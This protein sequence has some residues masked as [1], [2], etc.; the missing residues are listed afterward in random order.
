MA[1][2]EGA[3]A[4]ASARTAWCRR[5]TPRSFR[6]SARARGSTSRRWRAKAAA[7]TLAIPF[8]KQLTG[9]GRQRSRRR[10]RVM[11]T[12]APPARTSSTPRPCFASSRRARASHELDA[13][14][15]GDAAAELARRH[16]GTPTA[17]RTLLQPALPV[18]VRLEGR[19]LALDA[20]AQPRRNVAAL[21]PTPASCSSAARAAR[22]LRSASAGAAVMAALAQDLE[23]PASLVPWHSARDRFARLGAELAILAGAA[24][25]I[26]RDVSPPDAAGSRRGRRGG[27]GRDA[28]A[29]PACRT[30][31]IPRSRCSRSK[32]RSARPALAATLL[33][34]T[35]AGARAR[36]R[37]VA[38]PVVHACASCC[39]PLRAATAAMADA[40]EGLEV[41]EQAMRANL[42]SLLQDQPQRRVRLGRRD[43]R[44]RA[45]ANGR[46][47]LR[48]EQRL[49]LVGNL[50][51]LER[52]ARAVDVAAPD[53]RLGCPCASAVPSSRTT[54]C[55]TTN[56]APPKRAMRERT[57]QRSPCCAGAMNWQSR[58]N[59]RHRR[60]AP[61]ACA[62][63]L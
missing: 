57:S 58:R 63:G 18:T 10:R 14:R 28:A 62:S 6:A 61:R 23:L 43:D 22:C 59:Q 17:A 27:E 48:A 42:E 24:G 38:K 51:A 31:A 52:R 37:S 8:V 46:R 5:R 3:L 7:G 16:A 12:P 39:A 13:S 41:D 33:S 54:S 47:L 55:A 45:R 60:D 21:R 25:K 26:G 56:D 30:S 4:R 1:R 50:L 53:P 32:P 20:R 36:P 2:F 49:D 11:C 29:R 40:L 44:A 9:A 35:H 15:L 19:G 34:P